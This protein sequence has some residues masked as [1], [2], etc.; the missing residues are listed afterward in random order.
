MTHL[1][2]GRMQ[3]KNPRGRTLHLSFFCRGPARVTDS[4]PQLHN[5]THTRR[6]ACLWGKR[7][8]LC[9]FINTSDKDNKRPTNDKLKRLHATQQNESNRQRKSSARTS[10][11]ASA[12][13][14]GGGGGM[15]RAAPSTL[16]NRNNLHVTPLYHIIYSHLPNSCTT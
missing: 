9:T 2:R 4:A 15:P 16:L 12:N 6:F 14:Q 13:T 5:H 11:N 3:R 1:L 7:P 8:R 10:I